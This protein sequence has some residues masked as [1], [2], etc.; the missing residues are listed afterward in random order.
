MT[1]AQGSGAHARVC[2]V[3]RRP[4]ALFSLTSPDLPDCPK[5]RR[6]TTYPGES[7]R[8]GGEQKHCLRRMASTSKSALRLARSLKRTSV[9]RPTGYACPRRG[10]KALSV[11]HYSQPTQQTSSGERDRS[12]VGVRILVRFSE[13]QP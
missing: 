1:P 7:C 9:L 4:A 12:A 8:T 3:R 6:R 5:C 13:V 2:F 11:R 10:V